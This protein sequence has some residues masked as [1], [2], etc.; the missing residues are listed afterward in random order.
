M[1]EVIV[2]GHCGFIFYEGTDLVPPETVAKK[3]N[4]RCPRCLA[5][6]KLKPL[7]MKV[8]ATRSRGR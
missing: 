7:N 1:P 2:C 3:Y 4:Y 5:P 8:E 6:L